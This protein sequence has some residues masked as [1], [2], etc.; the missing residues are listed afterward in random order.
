M[1]VTYA[2]GRKII[3]FNRNTFRMESVEIVAYYYDFATLSTPTIADNCKLLSEVIIVD[4][5]FLLRQQ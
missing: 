1:Q 3:I 2:T 4:K 5:S